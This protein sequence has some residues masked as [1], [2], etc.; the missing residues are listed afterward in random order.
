M[1]EWRIEWKEDSGRKSLKGKG[2]VGRRK[3]PGLKKARDLGHLSVV[4]T[5]SLPDRRADVGH[6]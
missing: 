3:A 6:P 5:R 1:G 4:G 2:G